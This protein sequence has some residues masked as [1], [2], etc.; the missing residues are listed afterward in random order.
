M[1]LLTVSSGMSS[2]APLVKSINPTSIYFGDCPAVRAIQNISK[3][4][5][6]Y[7]FSF[8]NVEIRNL[9]NCLSELCMAAWASAPRRIM[10]WSIQSSADSAFYP[11]PTLRTVGEQCG[12]SFTTFHLMHTAGT[13]SIRRGVFDKSY[14]LSQRG[15]AMFRVCQ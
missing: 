11:S 2:S 13:D 10:H 9:R 6:Q 1:Q 8:T 15:R 3:T 12:R 7:N 14:P 4:H 5:M